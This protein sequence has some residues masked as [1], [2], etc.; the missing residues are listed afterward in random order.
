MS[1]FLV[2][3]RIPRRGIGGV[4]NCEQLGA[5]DLLGVA[6]V[7]GLGVCVFVTGPS[8]RIIVRESDAMSD[9]RA[10]QRHATLCR[11]L[12]TEALLAGALCTSKLGHEGSL[13]PEI[14]LIKCSNEI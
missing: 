4:R 1:R 5:W 6:F 12:V 2:S 3:T 8:S 14:D 11:A 9:T 10:S 7:A 13:A